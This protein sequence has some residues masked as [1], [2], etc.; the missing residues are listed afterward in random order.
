MKLTVVFIVFAASQQQSNRSWSSTINIF[1]KTGSGVKFFRS[2]S[3][4]RVKN[5]G[6]LCL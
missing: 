5:S 3:G 6:H 4:G 2:R 1:A